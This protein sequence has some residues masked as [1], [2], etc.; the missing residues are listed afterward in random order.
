MS[1]ANSVNWKVSGK[2]VGKYRIIYKIDEAKK[3]I[4]FYDVDLRRRVYR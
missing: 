3:E 2:I 1:F 4:V